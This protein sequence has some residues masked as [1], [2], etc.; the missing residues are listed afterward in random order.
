MISYEDLC[1]ALERYK[2]G[3]RVA[4][5][6][7]PPPVEQTY[8]EGGD[9]DGEATVAT[10]DP[11]AYAAHAYAA[12]DETGYAADGGEVEAAEVA[13]DPGYGGYEAPEGVEELAVYAGEEEEPMAGAEYAA[14]ADEA[15]QDVSADE[16]AAR[17]GGQ[18]WD[19]AEGAEQQEEPA[20]TSPEDEEREKQPD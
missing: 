12:A 13:A 20:A 3:E 14:E 18:S 19:M 6:E 8:A 2:A 11:D 16:E 10:M 9:Y 17:E 4:M 15:A 1:E 5:T 7:E